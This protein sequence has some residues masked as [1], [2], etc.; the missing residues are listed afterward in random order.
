M[1][2]WPEDEAEDGDRPVEEEAAEMDRPVEGMMDCERENAGWSRPI[3][4]LM[5]RAARMEQATDAKD[6]VRVVE[7]PEE[8][9]EEMPRPIEG[10]IN[11]V[12]IKAEEVSRPAEEKVTEMGRPVEGTMDCDSAGSDKRIPEC[13]GPPPPPTQIVN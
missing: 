6:A 11:C 12:R 7:W 10:P 2:K 4:G 8:E 9:A 13:I 5:T 3:E 1:E